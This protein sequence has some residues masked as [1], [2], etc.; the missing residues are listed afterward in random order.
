[1]RRFLPITLLLILAG[2]SAAQTV[3][4]NWIKH[5]SEAG[6]FAAIFPVAPQET[7]DTKKIPQGDVNSHVFMANTAGLLCLVGYTDYPA[8]INVDK[9]LELDR[10]NFVKE[11]AGTV[12]SS[13]RTSFS[14]GP[15]DQLPAL[16]FTATSQ[17]GT[18]KGLVIVAG[19]RAYVVV[20]FNRTGAD[21]KAD[22]ER[23]FTA[24]RLTS[25]KS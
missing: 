19:R 8:D 20:A 3:P 7:A 2:L 14:R 23:F 1:M 11:V 9:E 21:H 10:D 22:I 12:S 15:N 24:F 4:A 17:A 18:F 16:E 13:Q 25:K 6:S 5:D